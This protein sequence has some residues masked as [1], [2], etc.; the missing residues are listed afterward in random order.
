[1]AVTLSYE[2]AGPNPVGDGILFTVSGTAQNAKIIVEGEGDRLAESPTFGIAPSVSSTDTDPTYQFGPV[3]LEAGD[4][5]ADVV[6]AS[7]DD[8]GESMLAAIVYVYVE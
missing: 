4:Y 6:Y 7:G 5:L 8:E 3:F 1:M 2:P